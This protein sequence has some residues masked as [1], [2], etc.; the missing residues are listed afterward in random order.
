MGLLG[1]EGWPDT[2]IRLALSA[3]R[4]PRSLPQAVQAAISEKAGQFLQHSSTF[5][6]GFVLAFIKG[7]VR[8]RAAAGPLGE[9]AAGPRGGG[10]GGRGAA[11]AP[12]GHFQMRGRIVCARGRPGRPAGLAPR[13]VPRRSPA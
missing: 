1:H 7:W 9:R 8:G 12:R 5:I 6:A 4:S 3:P 13:A 2:P 10:A 11:G